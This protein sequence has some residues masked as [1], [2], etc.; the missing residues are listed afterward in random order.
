MPIYQKIIAVMG[1]LHGV[2]R[3]KTHPTKKYAFAGYDEVNE[4]LRP[5]FV[6]HGIVRAAGASKVTVGDG[7]TIIV[8]CEV[9]Y[10]DAQDGSSITIPMVA[11]QP[12]TGKP[13]AQQVGA[14]ISYAVRN[15]E[16][17]L[18]AL[19]GNPDSDDI[20]AA[21]REPIAEPAYVVQSRAKELLTMLQAAETEREIVDLNATI[22]AEWADLANVPGFRDA[23]VAT[24]TSALKRIKGVT[25]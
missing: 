15:V 25:S 17:K 7:G 2:A 3:T 11:V 19:T 13:D 10:F 20:S 18:F 6:E 21:Q 16:L 5:L 9:R 23:V 4:A 12:A 1:S 8:E 24:R 22:K 14:A